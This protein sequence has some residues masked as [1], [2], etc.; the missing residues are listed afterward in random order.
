MKGSLPVS[1]R[2][3][4]AMKLRAARVVK[5][6]AS[7]PVR[8][9]TGLVTKPRR[10]AFRASRPIFEAGG[11]A[12]DI[13]RKPPCSVDQAEQVRAGANSPGGRLWRSVAGRSCSRRWR[14]CRPRR[15]SIRSAR[16]CT[17][18]P[19][20]RSFALD[21]GLQRAP[22]LRLVLTLH[23]RRS[24][25]SPRAAAAP[26]SAKHRVDRLRPAAVARHAAGACR[27]RNRRA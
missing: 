19:R 3:A 14:G 21:L 16:P 9:P 13:R 20:E 10:P 2:S 4:T 11:S 12:L 7:R 26:Q 1:H 6:A 25:R 8:P 24:S 15:R 17:V 27:G 5:S 18:T 22:A 23:A